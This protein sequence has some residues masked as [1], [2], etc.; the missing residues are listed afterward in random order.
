MGNSAR[1]NLPNALKRNKSTAQQNT[2]QHVR[3][4]Q[5][6]QHILGLT[7]TGL[8]TARNE[9]ISSSVTARHP[10]LASDAT[11]EFGSSQPERIR[12]P[13]D[14]NLKASSVLLHEEFVLGADVA[15]SVH[16]RQRKH[17]DSSSTLNS[18]YDPQKAPMAISQQTSESSRR[19]L[20]LRKGARPAVKNASP[21]KPSKL[22]LFRLSKGGD[23][24]TSKRMTTITQ[25]MP[26]V[27]FTPS[28][29]LHML[30]N[31]D[32]IRTPGSAHSS[33]TTGFHELRHHPFSSTATV[34][35]TKPG[36]G[37]AGTGSKSLYESP[38]LKVNIRRPKA[39][40]K[41]W[42]DG[43]EG[44][45]S[46]DESIQE[47]QCQPS[48]VAGFETAFEGGQIRSAPEP[49]PRQPHTNGV[50]TT[51]HKRKS[52]PPPNHMLPPS[53][54]PPRVS[55]LNAKSSK[56]SLVRKTSDLTTRSLKP[57]SLA[58]KD[59][60]KTSVLDLSS[61]D[62]ERTP[63]LRKTPVPN[64]RPQIRDSIAIDAIVESDIVVGTAM[65]VNTNQGSSV[66]ATPSIRRVKRAQSRR[67]ENLPP[68][69][70]M[71]AQ[72]ATNDYLSDISSE[73]V[74]EE[75]D[76]ITFFPP[77][78]TLDRSPSLRPSFQE[79]SSDSASIESRRLMHVTRQ[80]EVLLAAI[81]SKKAALNYAPI[82]T[83]DPRIQ[84]LLKKDR[85]PSKRNPSSLRNST[86]VKAADVQPHAQSIYL[87]TDV[88]RGSS[89]TIE[90]GI[91]HDP[92]V[93]YSM[94]S[95]LTGTSIDAG[96]EAPSLRDTVSPMTLRSTS[97]AA[98]NRVSRS[99]FL[100][101]STS[102]SREDLKF[103]KENHY[104]AAL[105]RLQAPVKREEISSQ[106]FID[107]PYEGWMKIVA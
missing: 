8:N 75:N 90:T 53:A 78:P 47:P 9:S 71:P 80:E 46:D 84:A 83:S 87:N 106:D 5:K 49:D 2:W 51:F 60:K 72:N 58:S 42:F 17:S 63:T 31:P 23:R 102:S 54:I 66:Q 56:T 65:A 105:D 21:E 15:K 37:T 26:E 24:F 28:S 59:L 89:T 13:P 38:R 22:K 41:Y 77:T 32:R 61:S 35:V 88:D 73:P 55:T 1:F 34:H 91:S 96:T 39:G 69:P 99:T 95:F 11:T 70:P 107:F 98:L 86:S 81:R 64:M 25:P 68:K 27:N 30:E 16:S 33:R 29:A 50:S 18:Y 19:D 97:Q 48:F 62:D 44:D 57:S 79:M 45:S 6:A 4:E 74:Q 20:A 52:R 7:E 76:L 94:A 100:S 92:S 103:R 104:R 43:L 93:R 3:T 82:A 14:L 12:T 36:A 85:K 10:T 67:K 40:A 101:E